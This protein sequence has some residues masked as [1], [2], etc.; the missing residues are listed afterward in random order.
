M[1]IQE[2]EMRRNLQE[3]RRLKEE[4][5]SKDSEMRGLFR[6]I[7]ATSL[8]TQYDKD[9]TILRVNSRVTDLMQVSE[10]EIVGK[11]HADIS[12]FKPD[13]K[14]YRKFW[15]DLRHGQTRSLVESVQT[16]D[17][18]LWLSETFSPITDDHGNVV[19]I[20]NIGMD[21]SSTKVLERQ[22]RLQER[23]INR[24][25]DK[26]NEKEKELS[27]KQKY[28]EN[29]ELEMKSFNA[30]VDSFVI[31]VEFSRRGIISEANSLFYSTLGLTEDSVI[32]ADFASF[33]IPEN[34]TQFSTSLTI[35]S[36]G[37]EQKEKLK[38]KL[39]TG[40]FVY[41]N[42]NEFP[43][44]NSKGDVERIMLLATIIDG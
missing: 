35:L 20:I 12:S 34:I 3:M 21:I 8:V 37:K 19:K 14:D 11:N 13:N 30:A 32:G 4:T 28:I 39:P 10:E 33:L 1:K 5:E 38:L 7:D 42:A 40:S 2:V 17:K 31:K 43:I 41:I 44:A 15:E 29:T 16:R 9:G 24:Q 26:M 25:M 18:T 6:A 27:E 36:T 22:L 23:E